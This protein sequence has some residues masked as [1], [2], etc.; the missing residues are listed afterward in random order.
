M[1][2]TTLSITTLSITTIGIT[3]F[4]MISFTKKG[5]YS[6]GNPATSKKP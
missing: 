2:A 4:S 5:M 1:G 3:T 6:F